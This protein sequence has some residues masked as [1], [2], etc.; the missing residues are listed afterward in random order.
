M[1]KQN[2][3]LNSLQLLITKILSALSFL[4]IPVFFVFAIYHSL[5]CFDICKAIVGAT[6]ITVLVSLNKAL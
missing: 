4:F 3:L 1:K 6:M 2:K 5:I